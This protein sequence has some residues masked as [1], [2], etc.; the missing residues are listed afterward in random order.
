MANFTNYYLN[1][2]LTLNE[3]RVRFV[4]VFGDGGWD[5]CPQI[6]TLGF[7]GGFFM[8]RAYAQQKVT[9]T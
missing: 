2:T 5:S 7:L 6:V 8:S 9:V 1:P 4:L 3:K